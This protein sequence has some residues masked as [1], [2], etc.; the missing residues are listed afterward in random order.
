M[1]LI[2]TN[3]RTARALERVLNFTQHRDE[4]TNVNAIRIYHRLVKGSANM[5]KSLGS[6]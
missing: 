2:V 4:L 5:S 6:N 3:G 1:R